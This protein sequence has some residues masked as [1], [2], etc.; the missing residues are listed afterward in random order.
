MLL[1][2]NERNSGKYFF[3]FF[4]HY[5]LNTPERTLLIRCAAYFKPSYIKYFITYMRF[6]GST[7][8]DRVLKM[9]EA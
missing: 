6:L 2:V 8:F 3:V 1:Q 4:T 9:T 5:E 7:S